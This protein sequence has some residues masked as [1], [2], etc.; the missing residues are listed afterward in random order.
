MVTVKSMIGEP[1]KAKPIKNVTAFVDDP[2]YIIERKEDGWRFRMS[3]GAGTIR[4]QLHG[5]RITKKTGTFAESGMN[6]KYLWPDGYRSEK[7][8]RQSKVKW[9]KL[10]LTVFDGE[11]IAPIGLPASEVAGYMNTTPEK[12]KAKE[13][14]LGRVYYVIFD[15]LCDDGVDLRKLSL[16]DRKKRR[17]AAVAKYFAGNKQ[18]SVICES[19]F[20]E[21]LRLGAEGVIVKDLRAPYGAS[22]YKAKRVHTLD[23]VITGYEPGTGKYA[24]LIG[25]VICSVYLKG[26]LVEVGTVSGMPDA[27]RKHIT[28]HKKKY[29]GSVLE[30]AA[31]EMAKNRLRHPRWLRHRPE[32]DPKDCTWKKMM[33]DLRAAK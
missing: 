24:D 5:P 33:R 32:A 18:V 28:K 16:K 30:I 8:L 10:G 2:N 25:S 4:P 23:T 14:K 7:V 21:E 19:T 6:A 31:Q 26:K 29:L 11:I 20:E 15:I 13:E 12:A 22:W 3:F 9:S 17:D 27:V 1:P